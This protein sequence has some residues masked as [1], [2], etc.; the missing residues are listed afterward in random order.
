M[1]K[2]FTIVTVLVLAAA[3]LTGCSKKSPGADGKPVKLLFPTNQTSAEH[4]TNQGAFK[5]R[6][7]AARISGGKI[8]IEVHPGD[9]GTNESELIEKVKLGAADFTVASPS[10]MAQ[11]GVKEV[12]LLAF[13]YLF[14][15]MAHWE[16]V[17]DGEFGNLVRES[18]KKHTG[19]DFQVLAYFLSG[20]REVYAKK[21]I[22]G[23]SDMAG[24]KL[25]VQNSPV[26]TEYWTAV[27]AVP[28]SIGWG[29]LYQALQQ[30]TVDGAENNYASFVLMNHHT[31]ENGKFITETN[32]EFA[33]RPVFVNGKKFDSLS[34][35]QQGWIREALKITE[36]YQ[37]E[38][39]TA[40]A[41]EYKQKAISDGA[42]VYT[43][44]TAEIQFMIDAA[45]AQ[46]DSFCKKQGLEAELK[47]VRNAR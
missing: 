3:A 28:A 34:A 33:T 37:R 20:I 7:E 8:E 38:V 15:D 47:M 5:F 46:Q 14:D 17:M 10:F 13:T 32:H 43:P 19:N 39:D 23:Q 11:V 6:D 24:L 42:Q 21:F 35:E 12:D 30:K 45:V 9:L 41:E 25:R 1:K 29:E 18:V 31:T 27:G 26:C 16:R 22:K 2:L 4:A 44:T 40:L 36:K